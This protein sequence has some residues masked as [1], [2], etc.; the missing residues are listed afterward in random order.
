[1]QNDPK[2][3][4]DAALQTA[5]M[6]SFA[7]P[8]AG[9]V[10]AAGLGVFQFLF[11]LFYPQAPADPRNAAAT[12]ADLG[13][14][15]AD[16]EKA[17]I[18]DL[19][20]DRIDGIK[21]EVLQA[22]E[23]FMNRWADMAK[24][25]LNSVTP[26]PSVPADQYAV[27]TSD[28]SLNTILDA[29]FNVGLPNAVPSTIGADIKKLTLS[30]SS[31]DKLDPIQVLHHRTRTTGLYCLMGSLL[32]S[33]YKALVIWGWSKKVLN[34]Q[35]YLAYAASNQYWHKQNTVY[36]QNHAEPSWPLAQG[37]TYPVEPN[38]QAFVATGSSQMTEMLQAVDGLLLYS[39]YKGDGSILND[40]G[41]P[42]KT[43]GLYTQMIRNW[44]DRPQKIAQRLAKFSI[45]TDG[46]QYWY[47]DAEDGS[48]STGVSQKEHA[49]FQMAAKQGA[50]MASLWAYWG[51][52]YG[53]DG[54]EETDLIQFA[55]VIKAW[56]QTRVTVN[57]KVHKLLAGDTLQSVSK[58]HY[59]K[60][61]R[62][63]LL[64]WQANQAN[65]Q[66][67]TVTTAKAGDTSADWQRAVLTA[68]QELSIPD[69]Y[70][71]NFDVYT[72]QTGDTLITIA[73][74][75]YPSDVTGSNAELIFNTN[76]DIL[77]NPDSIQA[78]QVLRMPVMQ[79]YVS[80]KDTFAALAQDTYGSPYF[81]LA[82]FDANRDSLEIPPAQAGGP[83]YAFERATL[84]GGTVLLLPDLDAIRFHVYTTKSSDTYPDTILQTFGVPF[85]HDD[86]LYH[87]YLDALDK[88]NP[89]MTDPTVADQVFRVPKYNPFTQLPLP[90]SFD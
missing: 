5:I 84:K 32:V 79:H 44:Y 14:A 16:L 86:A 43:P 23:D 62:Y 22:N 37:E 41:S 52:V 57:F 17:L 87:A 72:V 56:K 58:I 82:I 19:W 15:I 67:I 30:E 28:P 33:Y 35:A 26:D 4:A 89:Y 88:A 70:A 7:V 20:T 42:N 38:W 61:D 45:Q 73:Q 3:I 2:R 66:A 46:T 77:T 24:L 21:P 50:L 74:F 55:Q 40:D 81:D 71:A 78:G 64:L 25:G 53:L 18:D 11:D 27:G 83:K 54:V 36:Q 75:W 31:D 51:Q 80:E 29:Y 9:P 69:A 34:H 6:G 1:M 76:K 47:L 63:D 68:G 65:T 10:I 8:G 90:V 85:V 49:E 60:C 48:T 12:K 13:Q 39:D 59:N